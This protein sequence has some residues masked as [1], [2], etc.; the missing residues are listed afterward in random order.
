M[1]ST[2]EIA[3]PAGSKLYL[4]HRI[5]ILVACA[6]V[7]YP[8]L[9]PTR[10]T[11]QISQYTSLL[12]SAISWPSPDQRAEPGPEQRIPGDEHLPAVDGGQHRLPGGCHPQCR[13]R[14]YVGRQYPDEA[15]GAALS[16]HR[17]ASDVAGLAGI[18]VSYT[19]IVA[20]DYSRAPAYFPMGFWFYLVLAVVILATSL[21]ELVRG[22]GAV[23]EPKMEMLED[24]HLF[25]LFLP[26]LAL[27]F[28]FCYLPLWGWRYAFF[29][30]TAGGNAEHGELRGPAVVHLPV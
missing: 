7:F 18:Y 16:H 27:A 19:Q 15:Q 24:Y 17:L 28:V 22:K 6:A 23:L 2:K 8:A 3:R 29:D 14:L 5:A 1:T 4:L 13:R 20:A 21:I 30:Y 12:T 26:I 25:L 9:S 11:T 10:I